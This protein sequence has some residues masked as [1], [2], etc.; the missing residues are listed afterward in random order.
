MPSTIE[1]ILYSGYTK[2]DRLNCIFPNLPP[3]SFIDVYIDMCSFV[4]QLYKHEVIINN[5][6]IVTSSIINMCAHYRQFFTNNGIDSTF[7]IIYSR[8]NSEINKKFCTGYN[9]KMDYIYNINT[10]INSIISDNIDLLKVLVPYLPDIHFVESPMGYE[11]GAIIL[12]IMDKVNPDNT[13]FN[14]VISKDAYIYQTAIFNNTFILRPLKTIKDGDQSY[15]IYSENLLDCI[16]ASKKIQLRNKFLNYGLA[17][18]I[19][20]LSSVPER[21]IKSLLNINTVVNILEQAVDD[22][23]ISNEYNYHIMGLWDGLKNYKPIYE[24]GQSAFSD[25]I[26]A[27]DIKFQSM[28]YANTLESDTMQRFENLYD[29]E[30]VKAINNKYFKDNP[31]DLNAL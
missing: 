2:Y 25:R 8:N 4:K 27:V 22:Y 1:E 19:M 5:Y 21:N 13:R 23:K 14:M 15:I 9:G 26:K 6:K 10:Q 29:P 16:Y 3:G 20:A 7:Y 18:V 24:L 28:V 17:P 31:L 11:T 30:A 12:N